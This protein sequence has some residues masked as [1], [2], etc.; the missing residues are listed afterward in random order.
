M[1]SKKVKHKNHILYILLY[2]VS[3]KG[4]FQRQKISVCLGKGWEW[5]L[6]QVIEIL[7]NQINIFRKLKLTICS[8]IL[9]LVVSILTGNNTITQHHLLLIKKEV[10]KGSGVILLKIHMQTGY[11][12]LKSK[13]FLFYSFLFFLFSFF[14]LQE[15]FSLR[16]P[17]GYRTRYH[18]HTDQ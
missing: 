7:Q 13:N 6:F 16:K 1:L 4:K 14:R 10:K 15:E 9:K 3:R 8:R 11:T 18:C 5:G 2:E 12:G 17:T